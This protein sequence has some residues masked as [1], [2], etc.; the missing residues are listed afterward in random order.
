MTLLSLVL[1]LALEQFRPLD[2]AR[3]LHAPLASL[4]GFFERRFNDGEA[5]HGVIAWCLMVLPAVALCF[6]AYQLLDKLHSILGLLFS[7]GV[8]YLTMG[9]RHV[10]HYFTRIHAALRAQ[11]LDRA[12]HLLGNWRGHLHETSSSSEVARL[13]LEEGLIGA[14]RQVFAVIVFFVLFGPAGAVLYRMSDYFA[15]HWGGHSGPSMGKFGLFARQAFDVI[16]WLPVRVTAMA[17]TIVGDFE[18]A[19][20]CWRTQAANWSNRVEGILLA[21]GAGAMG[22]RLGGEIQQSSEA[23][24]RPEMGTGDDAEVDHLQS[25]VGLIR[26]SL[27]LYIL[28]L[29]FAAIA[30]MAG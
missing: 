5:S 12:R 28:V 4:G 9:F 13:T 26:R 29:L 23:V 11:E 15:R 24:D 6:V 21:S 14:H 10:S 18:D 30:S 25:L 16:E 2:A 27:L 8:L 17:F 3:F 20:Y 1:V 19:A 7:V 22:V